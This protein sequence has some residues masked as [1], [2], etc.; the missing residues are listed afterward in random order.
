MRYM[1]RR[2]GASVVQSV[3]IDQ[4]RRPFSGR[5][6]YSPVSL[7]V[8]A[9]SGGE[10][11][12][13]LLTSLT[14]TG[15][16]LDATGKFPIAQ[17]T[18][19][20]N[21]FITLTGG[22]RS[23]SALTSLTATSVTIT[24]GVTSFPVLTQHTSGRLTLNGGTVGVA[25]LT[26]IDGTS[27]YVSGGATLSFPGVTSYLFVNGIGF[28]T[29]SIDWRWQRSGS[30]ESDHIHRGIGT[31]LSG[32]KRTR[33]TERRCHRSQR[34]FECSSRLR[35]SSPGVRYMLQQTARAVNIS[36]L[37][38]IVDHSPDS[39]YSPVSLR[40]MQKAVVRSSLHC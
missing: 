17:L 10:I 30:G 37:T 19:I 25:N 1:L 29:F 40:S 12:A 3:R 5:L 11:I 20:T 2:T 6:G 28:G 39:W 23:F 18:S 32:A 7:S 4:H 36:A 14:N 35:E 33:G 26:N 9:K 8:N 34:G 13:P 22:N 15:L 16:S 21:G 27:L 38:S 31:R 24:E